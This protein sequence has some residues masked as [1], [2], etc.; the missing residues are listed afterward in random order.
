MKHYGYFVGVD[1]SK[2]TLDLSVI[3]EGT[4]VHYQKIENNPKAINNVL[5]Q[6]S[7]RFD[8][9][10]SQLLFCMEHT[11]FYG[12]HLL[13]VLQEKGVDTWLEPPIQIK[14]SLGFTRGK[15]D[16]VDA[17]RIAL[18][19]FKNRTEVKLWQPPREELK[20][21]KHLIRIRKRILKTIVNLN[22]P[23]EAADFSGKEE[24]KILKTSFK[25]SITALKKDLA[26]VDVQI[27]Q[28]IREDTELKRLFQLITSV[29]GVG[30]VTATQIIV[31]TN[32]F[33]GISEAKKF[34]C[35]SGVAPFEHTSGTS[36]NG[37]P[38]VSNMADKNMKAT[39]H[40]AAL[41]AIHYK[42]EL[43]DFYQRKIQEGKNK[44]AVINAVRN[45]LIHR[46]FACVRDD[47]MYK[48]ILG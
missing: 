11:G 22:K 4:Q 42:G 19:A 24:K 46:V 10:Y 48:P 16:K 44:M 5:K 2:A 25:T 30:K 14:R 36:V 8:V 47:R 32:E 41:S 29:K 37:R 12:N 31:A 15:N 28:L 40:M 38:H 13:A 9:D 3:K 17:K 18:Y 39:L 33:K 21:L 26:K 34:A 45:K 43:Q 20:K 23:L 1:I 27:Q 6:L 35:Y 7:K